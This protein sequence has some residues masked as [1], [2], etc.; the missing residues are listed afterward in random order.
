MYIVYFLFLSL[1]P[2]FLLAAPLPF[3]EKTLQNI[4]Y[5]QPIILKAS[6]SVAP[7]RRD[8]YPGTGICSQSTKYT[9]TNDLQTPLDAALLSTKE[10]GES[11]FIRGN[12]FTNQSRLT[13]IID[14]LDLKSEKF[15][16]SSVG[17]FD[18]QNNPM[19][20]T[21]AGD[22]GQKIVMHMRAFWN[23]DIT[24]PYI[25]SIGLNSDDGALVL[26]ANKPV[27]YIDYKSTTQ[28]VT[29]QYIVESAGMYPID[30]IYYQ[31]LNN[32]YFE[33]GGLPGE[34]TN[35]GFAYGP[36]NITLDTLENNKMVT[37]DNKPIKWSIYN[38][39]DFYGAINGPTALECNICDQDSDCKNGDKCLFGICQNTKQACVTNANCGENCAACPKASDICSDGRCVECSSDF[40]C[41]FEQVCQNNRCVPKPPECTQDSDCKYAWTTTEYVCN[42]TSQKCE[43]KKPECVTNKD[44]KE[45]EICN[46]DRKCQPY[47]KTMSCNS[48]DACNI[49][50]YCENNLHTCVPLPQNGCRSQIQCYAG[51][52]CDLTVRT[53][54]KNIPDEDPSNN[55][56]QNGNNSGVNGGCNQGRTPFAYELFV[57]IGLIYGFKRKLFPKFMG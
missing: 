18:S 15:K 46:L 10:L 24:P 19:P 4:D 16:F 35:T 55:K 28:H 14:F 33:L 39:W 22:D 34:P 37:W 40:N 31:N 12:I 54:V 43:L 49:N 45:Y 6:D 51:F 5:N 32:A 11:I 3:D 30:I 1:I 26:I 48:D 47:V 41:N 53:C 21:S 56:S 13:K 20:F 8:R 9:S 38:H 25:G 29:R 7:A 50:N 17:D 27:L 23:L 42:Q 52:H 2:Q 36:T 44:C 57:M